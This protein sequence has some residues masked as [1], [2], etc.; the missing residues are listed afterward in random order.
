MVALAEQRV[1]RCAPPRVA[2]HRERPQGVAVIALPAR[3]EAPPLG[4]VALEEV[5]PGDLERRLHRFRSAGHEVDP[6]ETL[7]RPG[8]E[9]VG[10]RL[11][12]L[13]G[14]EAGVRERQAVELCLDGLDHARMVVAQR[15]HRGATGGVQVAL[16]GGVDDV[17]AFAAR[18]HR[19]LKV[20]VSVEDV[21]HGVRPAPSIRAAPGS[22]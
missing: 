21:T 13:A 4:L 15:R 2:A 5:L 11:R 7:R 1:E 9:R 14:E 18:G 12:R 20:R 10:E 16:A 6:L 19:R 17:H 3:D 22:R 8:N